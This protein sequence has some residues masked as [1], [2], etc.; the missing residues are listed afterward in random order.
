MAKTLT[1]LDS[2]TAGGTTINNGGLTVDGKNYVS[3]NGINANNQ[4]ITNVADGTNSNDAVN[5]GQLQNVI[6]SIDKAPTVKAKDANVTVTEGTNAAGGKEYIVGLGNTINVGAAHPVTV[7]GNA[8]HVTGLQNTDWSVDN[9]V[10]VP[11]RA[12]T[13]DQLKKV[14]D[15]VNANKDQIDKNKQAIADNKQNITTNA[16]NIANN[17]QNI[18]KNAGDIVTINKTIEKGLNFDGDSG[19]TINKKLG[20]TVAVKGGATGTLSDN[21]IGVVS[22]GTGTLNVKLAK[23][24]TGLDSV[25]AG[26]TTINNGGLTVGGK[27]YV[28]PNGINANDQKVTNVA[29]GDVAP[30]S[31]D[32]VNGS[33][34][35]Q[36]KQD[37]GDQITN[38]KNDLNDKIDTTKTDLINKGLRFNADNDDEKTNKLGSKVTVN[39]DDNITTEITQTGDDT[40]IALK[41]KKDLNVRTVTATDTVKAGDVTM[42]KQA[43]GA[44]PGN[45]GNYITGLDNKTWDPGNVVSGRAA[46]EDQLKQALANQTATGLKFDAN[47]G[48]VQTSKLGSTVIVQGEGKAADSDYS[49]ENIKTFIKQ[50]AATGNTTIDVKMSKNLKAESVKVGKGDNKDGVSITGPDGANGTDGKVGITGKDGKDAVSMSGKDGVGHIGLSGKD[51][52]SADITAEKGDPDIEGNEI[53]RIKY[54]DENGKTH[55][56]ATKDDGMKYGGDS[57]AVINKKLNEQVNV[58]GGITDVSKLTTEDNLGVVSDGSNNLKVRMAKDLKGLETVTTKDTAGNTTVVNGGGMR[59][60]LLAVTL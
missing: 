6:N 42:G 32:A 11:G 4:K 41:L 58:I 51:G 46:T 40:K 50:D 49:G 5:Y 52:R 47:V 10:A 3:P 21:N 43:D 36:V 35:H 31:K 29:N 7:D 37:L 9:P 57:G 55:Q 59:L 14:N 44:N 53:T 1:G 25:T 23:T 56:V 18:A 15:T 45:T 60:H 34:L 13:E 16:G 30:N 8:G 39:G 20:D 12:A 33:Q 48:G 17:T 38:T 19:A 24:L 22:D 26:D 27:N 28:S 2:V 54:Q